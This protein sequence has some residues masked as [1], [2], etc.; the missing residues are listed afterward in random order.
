MSQETLITKST[1]GGGGKEELVK[2]SEEENGLKS[3][4]EGRKSTTGGDFALT[5]KSG[6]PMYPVDIPQQKYALVGVAGPAAHLTKASS[7]CIQVSGFF[8]TE[9]ERDEFEAEGNVH[10]THA[11]VPIARSFYLGKENK[12]P[13]DQIKYVEETYSQL[14]TSCKDNEQKFDEYVDKKQATNNEKESRSQLDKD[15]FEKS[16]KKEKDDEKLRAQ[17]QKSNDAFFKESK[18]RKD[19]KSVKRTKAT[20]TVLNQKYA[21]VSIYYDQKEHE[22]ALQ[23]DNIFLD[24]FC[25]AVFGGFESQDQANAHISDTLQHELP[26]M[27]FWS[28]E[29]YKPIYLDFVRLQ[30]VNPGI[31]KIYKHQIMQDEFDERKL[32]A[33]NVKKVKAK[34]DEFMAAKEK[35]KLEEAEAEKEKASSET[36]TPDV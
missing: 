21:V 35:K 8:P 18:A 13:E 25:V 15:D 6:L 4:M 1:E 31:K 30:V 23:S 34:I 32:S 17:I 20:E 28:V 24:N 19:I 16:K 9:R 29:M 5:K 3:V 27:P 12:S 33:V 26:C 11:K 14:E 36:H 10:F 2:D 22:Q 7:F